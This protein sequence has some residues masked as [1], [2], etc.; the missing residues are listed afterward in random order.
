MLKQTCKKKVVNIRD[1]I[2]NHFVQDLQKIII[3]PLL[4][5]VQFLYQYRFKLDE[6]VLF[7]SKE[8]GFQRFGLVIINS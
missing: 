1:S 6:K 2:C 5:Q 4:A 3:F 8:R 7:N